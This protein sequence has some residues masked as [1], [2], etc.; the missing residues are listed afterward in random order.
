MFYRLKPLLRN[1]PKTT[2]HFKSTTNIIKTQNLSNPAQIYLKPP[3]QTYLNP[4][5]ATGNLQKNPW[6]TTG[7]R[8]SISRCFKLF[9]SQILDWCS[10]EFGRLGRLW[11]FGCLLV[12][13]WNLWWSRNPMISFSSLVTIYSF[14]ASSFKSFSKGS[15]KRVG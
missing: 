3:P 7:Q 2:C 4:L 11:L 10:A 5:K 8:S 13:A 14:G 9:W 1:R 12:E 6:E 15:L